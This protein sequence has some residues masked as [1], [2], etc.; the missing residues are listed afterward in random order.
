M[1][2][3]DNGFYFSPIEATATLFPFQPKG[4]GTRGTREGST[5]LML[6]IIPHPFLGVLQ[7]LIPVEPQEPHFYPEQNQ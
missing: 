2:T 5:E 3:L 6:F 7:I 4:N 1:K